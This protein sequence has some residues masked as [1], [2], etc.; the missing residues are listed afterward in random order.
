MLHDAHKFQGCG[1]TPAT[2]NL[3]GKNFAN[4][5]AHLGFLFC[6]YFIKPKLCNTINKMFSLFHLLWALWV[7]L[8]YILI[9]LDGNTGSQNPRK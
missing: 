5:G 2:W 3:Y 4:K 1:E 9:R 6:E 7:E 8:F